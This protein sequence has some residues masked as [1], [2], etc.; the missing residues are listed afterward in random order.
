MI[1]R[2]VPFGTG[3]FEAARPQVATSARGAGTTS[4]VM[5]LA[6]VLLIIANVLGLAWSAS[7]E[8]D[9]STHRV[10]RP[11]RVWVIGANDPARLAALPHIVC[12]YDGSD[13]YGND[14]C[15]P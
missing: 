3:F 12:R 9:P 6:I 11:Q 2:S 1:R 13:R 4:T 14:A 8:A 7:L 15:R 5:W 10:T